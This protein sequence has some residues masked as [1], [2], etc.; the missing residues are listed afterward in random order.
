MIG[1]MRLV[2]IIIS[3]FKLSLCF[4]DPAPKKVYDTKY[5]EKIEAK[6]KNQTPDPKDEEDE[7]AD[8][9]P[10]TPLTPKKKVKAEAKPEPK[11]KG[12]DEWT[13]VKPKKSATKTSKEDDE[14]FDPF[15]DGDGDEEEEAAAAAALKKKTEE[16][17]KKKK[18]P[19]V[20]K[21]LVI[22]EVKPYDADTDLN[23][24][25]A[26]IIEE[27]AMDGLVWKIGFKLEP[28]AYGV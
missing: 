17:K 22:F 6:E 26:K 3:I 10:K 12:D 20:A 5:A 21:S 25:G 18:A 23:A 13:D 16:A 27:V 28:V 11:V 1:K 14:D 8:V 24:L 19:V 4:I 15:A 9:K 7:W 2:S